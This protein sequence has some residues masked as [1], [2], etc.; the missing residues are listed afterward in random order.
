MQRAHSAASNGTLVD[1][2]LELMIAEFSPLVYH[3]AFGILHDPGL[4]EDAVQETMIKAWRHRSEF[5]GD[6]SFKT[7]IVRIGRNTAIDSLRRRRDHITSAGEVPETADQNANSDIER[8][9]EGRDD[10]VELARA[11]E[12]LDELSRT[13]IVLREVDSMSY[14]EIAEA[15]EVPVSTVKTRLL[16]ARRTLQEMLEPQ[17]AL[18]P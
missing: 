1:H 9:A 8:L 11:L 4:A 15:L 10:M 17:G 5:R 13:I 3:V 6:S 7:W 16:R 12:T 2:E 14:Q 18:A